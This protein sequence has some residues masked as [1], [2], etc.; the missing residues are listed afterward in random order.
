MK[1]LVVLIALMFFIPGLVYGKF[2][3]I[4]KSG[5]DIVAAFN[6]TMTNMGSYVA[7]SFFMAQFIKFFGWSNL[8]ILFAIKGANALQTSGF[9]IPVILVLF[10]LLCVVLDILLGSASAKWAIMAPIFIQCSCSAIP[11]F[12]HYHGIQNRDSVINI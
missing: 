8:G 11:S 7:M 4:F 12:A 3:G 1:G 6:E 10:T 2:A 5:K 9:P